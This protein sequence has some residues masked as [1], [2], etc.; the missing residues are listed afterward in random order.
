MYQTSIGHAH[1][2]V[3]DL[4]RSVA[5]YKDYLGLQV[6]EITG[7]TTAFL[8]SGAAH[9]ELA[10]SAL[11]MAALDPAPQSVGLFH[12]A[13][14]VP[15]KRRFALAYSKLTEGGI[16]VSPVDHKIGWGAYFK[17]PDGNLLEIYCDTR[18]EPDGEGLWGGQNRPLAGERILAALQ[19]QLTG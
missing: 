17:D 12:L 10:L 6:T 18:R 8:T 4:A 19:E 11:G 5:F 7:E 3:R 13:F 2:F 16:T 14:D 15:D 1:L 9:H